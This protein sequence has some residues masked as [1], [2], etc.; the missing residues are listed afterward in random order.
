[1]PRSPDDPATGGGG[2]Y[3]AVDLETTGLDPAADRII[4]I[5][6]VRFGAEGPRERFRTFVSPGRPLPPAI[7]MLTKIE[8]ADLVGAPPPSLAVHE[9]AAF[10]RGLPLVAHNAPFD[11][12]FL[13]EAGLQPQAPA[14]DSYE[15][16]SV[17]LPTATRLDLGSLAGS[18]GVEISEAHRALADAEA[19]AEVFLRLLERLER[20]PAATLRDLVRLAEQSAWSLAPL[21]A[22]ALD[23]RSEDAGGRA[24]PSRPARWRASRRPCRRRCARCRSSRRSTGTRSRRAS[25]RRA[26]APTCS[27]AS[28]RARARSRWR[29]P[30]RPTSRTTASSP[31]RRGRGPASRSPTSCRRSRTRCAA[32]SAS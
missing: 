22:G 1:M 5:G 25:P 28:R 18:L 8:D 26:A 3:V 4:E 27:P 10:A 21:F 14:Y 11:L 24:M 12:G 7:R 23:R 30:S 29:A 20:L 9:F 32:T 15:L 6:A 2:E 16:A 17:L 31:S 19:T 13:A